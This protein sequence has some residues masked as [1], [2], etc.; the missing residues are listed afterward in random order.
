MARR[1]FV[2]KDGRYWEIGI[3]SD[4]G[5]PTI[6][7]VTGRGGFRKVD[8]H[9]QMNLAVATERLEQLVR[10]KC[11][12]GYV[13]EGGAPPSAAAPATASAATLAGL[14]ERDPYR[15]FHAAREALATTAD[16]AAVIAVLLRALEL[17][18]SDIDEHDTA[19]YN[20]YFPPTDTD[21]PTYDALHSYRA[22]YEKLRTQLAAGR[23]VSLRAL[24]FEVTGRSR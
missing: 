10:E 22:H 24:T 6:V 20:S 21:E 19:N 13:E 5:G 15:G 14:V 18:E 11:K 9:K 7:T 17:V 3:E 12:A 1:R 23:R 2:A 4:L 16:P 8:Q